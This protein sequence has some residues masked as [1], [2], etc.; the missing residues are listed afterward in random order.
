MKTRD[1]LRQHFS[2][3]D[4]PVHERRELIEKHHPNGWEGYRRE[5]ESTDDEKVVRGYRTADEDVYLNFR[6]LDGETLSEANERVAAGPDAI[7]TPFDALNSIC[8]DMGGKVGYGRGWHTLIVGLT[9]AG[10]SLLGLQYMGH[11]IQEGVNVCYVS[12]EMSRDQLITRLMAQVSGEKIYRL[13]PGES[14]DMQARHRATKAIRQAEGDAYVNERPVRTIADLEDVVQFHRA[15]RG[16]EMFVVDYL[17][18]VEAPDT[19]SIASRIRTISHRL[20][21]LMSEVGSVSV[22]L[23]QFSREQS[24]N[25]PPS[26]FNLKGGSSLEQDSDVIVL[27]DHHNWQH[28]DTANETFSWLHIAKNRH[29]PGA[30]VPILWDWDSLKAVELGM[31]MIPSW[32]KSENMR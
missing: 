11:A 7:P 30:E 28:N 10:K 31:D 26:I 27:I 25:E 23:S 24:S 3:N 12:N 19:N 2:E 13:E 4:T 15:S 22:A 9:S 16:V 17:Q 18:L 29:G 6:P 5:A 1:Q 8:G 21:D 14:V 32:V 20:R